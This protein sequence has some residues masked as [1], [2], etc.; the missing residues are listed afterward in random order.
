MIVADIILCLLIMLFYFV[1]FPYPLSYL[2]FKDISFGE[3][4]AVSSII[5]SIQIY[6]LYFI[7]K[8]GISVLSIELI[9][10]VSIIFLLL[11]ILGWKKKN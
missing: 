11:S 9:F 1:I 10:A 2:I 8:N 6:I 3:R 4:F 5:G 7:L